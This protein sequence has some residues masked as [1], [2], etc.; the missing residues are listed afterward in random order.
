M[1]SLFCSVYLDILEWIPPLSMPET[2]TATLR[3]GTTFCRYVAWHS[4]VAKVGSQA[5]YLISQGDFTHRLMSEQRFFSNCCD[6]YSF[7]ADQDFPDFSHLHQQSI[8]FE[9]NH[10][11]GVLLVSNSP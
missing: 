3:F 2:K 7:L 4:A 10:L 5:F 11:S 6:L 9:W 1:D 8:V